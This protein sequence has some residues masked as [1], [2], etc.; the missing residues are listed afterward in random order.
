MAQSLYYIVAQ[1]QLSG[2]V[3][4]QKVKTHY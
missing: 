1:S 4:C 3:N 2:Q